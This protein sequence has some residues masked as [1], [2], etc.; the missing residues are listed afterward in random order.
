MKVSNSMAWLAAAVVVLSGCADNSDKDL[1]KK[2]PGENVNR[3]IDVQSAEGA[4]TDAMLYKHH[5]TG[6]H[7]NSLGRQKVRLMLAECDSCDEIVVYL[8]NVGEGELLDKRKAAVEMYLK[9]TD[10]ENQ[11]R[12]HPA[13]PLLARMI[14]VESTLGDS[15]S[16]STGAS[17][18]AT[19]AH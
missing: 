1:F 15:G 6:G 13:Q 8:N 10:G 7:L 3:V 5:F 19:A 18:G 4:R 14:K 2:D 11:A 9:T 17:S 12:L 16:A